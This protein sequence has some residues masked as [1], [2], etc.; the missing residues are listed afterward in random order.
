VS[1]LTLLEPEEVPRR[2]LK[3]AGVTAWR[4]YPGVRLYHGDCVDVLR[5]LPTNSIDAS[6]TDP[7]YGIGF[8]G[9]EWD[10]FRPEIVEANTRKMMAADH[11][12]N[13]DDPRRTNPNLKG[14][15]RSPAM[16]PSQIDYDRSLEGQRGFQSWCEAWGREVLRVMKPGAYGVICGAPRSAHRMTSGLEDAGFWIIDSLAWLFGQGFP[17]SHNLAGAWNGYGSALKPGHEPIV[18]I[19]KP[20]TLTIDENVSKWGVGALNIDGCRIATTGEDAQREDVNALG[21]WPANVALDDDAAQLLDAQ[22]GTRKSGANQTRRGSDEIHES[23]SAYGTFRGQF[24]C[25]PARGAQSGG[26]SRFFYVAKPSR[27]E[28]DYGCDEL[29]LRTAGECTDRRDGTAGL[30]PYAGAGRSGGGRNFHPTVK[31]VALMRWLVRLITPPGRTVLDPFLGS[32]TTALACLLENREF[33]GIEREAD[34]L[35]IP[36]ARIGALIREMRG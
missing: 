25:T 33:I 10:T 2:P 32:G 11:G 20:F 19:Q 15:T 31:P 18:L 23:R 13:L 5:A 6:V 28:R 35:V 17:K 36:D 8:M 30:T 26:A 34:Y 3:L 9:K 27:A 4:E 1:Q 21:R 24:E 7:P 22:A 14:R 29:P 12:F 16:S